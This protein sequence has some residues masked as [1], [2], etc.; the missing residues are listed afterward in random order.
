MKQPTFWQH[1]YILSIIMLPLAVAY[2]LASFLRKL[3]IS[4]YTPT[5]PVI[6]IGNVTVGGAGKTPTAIAIAKIMQGQGKKVVF[7]SRGYGGKLQGPVVVDG[8]IH[9]A[10]DTGDEPLLLSKIATTIIG[11]DRRKGAQM[12]AQIGADIIIMDDGLQNPSIKKTLSLLV[13]DGNYG[14]GNGLILPAG[15]LRESV[16]NALAKTAAVIF[17]GDD[18]HNIL[19]KLGAANIIK[20]KI[21]AVENSARDKKY[22]AFAGIANP[23]KFFNSLQQYKYNVVEKFSFADHYNYSENDVENL[24]K[25]A[26]KN[27]AILITTEKDFVRL[28]KKQQENMQVLPI[29]IVWDSDIQKILKI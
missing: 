14:I 3:F 22:V 5:I 12:A 29:E 6:C 4:Q 26:A 13:I 15:P 21:V 9:T 19:P 8:A 11:C 1:K 18:K 20:A 7:L 17:I 27:G 25:V 10:S 16:K 28:A 23:E 2:L 24:R